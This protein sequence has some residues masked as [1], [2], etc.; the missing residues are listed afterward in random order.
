[1]TP[2]L[3]RGK[4]TV[5]TP[6]V[7]LESLRRAIQ[8]E[9]ALVAQEPEHGF[10]FLVGRPLARLLGYTERWLD[11]IPEPTIAS[12]A[13]TGNPFS[14]GELQPGEHVV[15]VG[16]RR[17]FRQSH[18]GQNGR[19]TWTRDRCRHDSGNDSQS[20]HQR[21]SGR[22][23]QRRVS[24]GLR[25]DPACRGQPRAIRLAANFRVD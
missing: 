18:R 3:T 25:R 10:H 15:D 13:G 24:R 17:G 9:Y 11:G 21:N 14:V 5:E 4:Q 8:E 19:R 22:Y 23:A 6:A 1:M 2:T 12:F 20:A 16:F 7:D